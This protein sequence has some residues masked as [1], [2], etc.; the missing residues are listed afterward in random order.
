MSGAIAL[1][2]NSL[3]RVR[4]LV[5][6]MGVLLAGFQV[7]LTLVAGSIEDSG[8]FSSIA[9]LIPDFMRQLM[10]PAFVS[11]MSFS[12]IVCVGY[13]HVAVMGALMGLTI[14]L[15]TEP[16][17]EIDKGFMDLLLSR[18]LAR[19][20]I[21]ARSVA[22]LAICAVF[23]LLMMAL[24]TWTG[25]RYFAPQNA[26]GPGFELIRSLVVNLLMLMFSWGG[27]TLALSSISRRRGVAGAAAGLLALS[28]FLLDYVARAW[29]PAEKV[30]WLSPFRYYSP[31]ELVTGAAIPTKNLWVLGSIAVAGTLLAFALFS[32]R[33]I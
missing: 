6:T 32:R 11:L 28:T 27:I 25:M 17:A 31:M 22:L 16:A 10:G 33:D 7:L 20:W 18:P 19:P 21:V 3:R 13:F 26:V 1:L 15:A 24:G 12:G 14:A 8:G 29:D 4:F 23:V 30:A 5:L 9:D 2:L